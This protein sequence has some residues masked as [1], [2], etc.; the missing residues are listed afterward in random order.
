MLK[1]YFATQIFTWPFYLGS[2]FKREKRALLN[3][4]LNPPLIPD[5]KQVIWIHTLS[6]GEVQ[7]AIPLL[8]ALRENLPGYFLVFTVATAS[9]YQQ[10]L[11]RAENLADLIWPGPIDLYTVIRKYLKSFHPALFI[12]VESDI[13]PG[14]LGEIKRRDIP[15]VLVNAALSERSFKRLNKI[16]ILK[17]LLFGSF[18]F[19][20]AA[21]KGDAERL[22]KLL[23]E[24]EI[25]FFG[26]LKYEIP[27]P[28]KEK[29]ARLKTELGPFL[30]RPVIVCGS[31]HPGEEELLFEGFRRFGRG[32]LVLCP[33]HPKRAEE[34][35]KL[36]REKG[37]KASKRSNPSASEVI[38]VDTLGEL[39]ALYSLG[40]VAFVGGSLVPV[41]GH[42][43]FEPLVFG[44][45]VCFGPYVESIS[46]LAEYLIEK[47]IG[48]K[49][50]NSKNIADLWNKIVCQQKDLKDKALAI[51]KEFLGVSQQ[52]VAYLEK[53]LGHK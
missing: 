6:V 32:S 4:R 13:W 47:Q 3:K 17:D 7:A 27:P 9:G 14:L 16:P 10:A 46:D 52:Y 29:I 35:L 34:L 24:R 49:I 21:T 41:G 2:H 8:K 33:R 31:T 28:S 43:L 30:K 53:F 5:T 48:F 20:G 50:D 18:S 26:N 51:K 36:A 19:I 25:F 1:F 39:A 37:F 44:L 11:K 12:L 22:K 45:P 15:L 42:N 40:D 23:P 38:I